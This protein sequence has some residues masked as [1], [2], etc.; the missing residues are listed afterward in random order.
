M[1]LTEIS[2]FFAK[3]DISWQDHDPEALTAT[4]IE[5]GTV[6]SPLFGQLNGRNAIRKSYMEWF[7]T[8]PDTEFLA[9][10]QLIDGNKVVQFIKLTATQQ[11]DFCGYPPT[12]KRFHIQ[13][14]S[15][16]ILSDEGIAEEIRIYDFTG[17]L[18]Q[19]GAIQAKPGF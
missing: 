14:A 18:V 2:E 10:H 15:L 17:V 8:F 3:R 19:L 6:I 5:N 4:H 13:A 1:N 16:Y 9:E 7:T 12:G 11:S